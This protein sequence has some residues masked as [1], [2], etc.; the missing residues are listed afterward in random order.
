MANAEK[1][2]VIRT[3][4]TEVPV[5]TVELSELEAKCLVALLGK[6]GGQSE[7]RRVLTES[8]GNTGRE[9]GSEPLY[10]VLNRIVGPY[11]LGG[12][13]DRHV[14]GFYFDSDVHV[15]VSE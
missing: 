12:A 6:F 7:P 13:D 5:I 4:T 9:E 3:V 10:R 1:N 15:I 2:T 8:Y 14:A 11:T